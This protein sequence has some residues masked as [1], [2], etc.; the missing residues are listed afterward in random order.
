[1]IFRWSYGL[2][3]HQA[4]VYLLISAILLYLGKSRQS[5]IISR[6]SLEF[7]IALINFLTFNG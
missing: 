4:T 5:E 3:V 6:F 1:M 7:F 2:V